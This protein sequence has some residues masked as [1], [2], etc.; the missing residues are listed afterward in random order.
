[1]AKQDDNS[2]S[3]P[4]PSLMPGLSTPHLEL[5]T[6]RPPSSSM[7]NL[8]ELTFHSNSTPTTPVT[9]NCEAQGGLIRR[10]SMPVK[11]LP[12]LDL[13]ALP[14]EIQ[15]QSDVRTARRRVETM[16]STLSKFRSGIY[17]GSEAAARDKNLLRRM[18]ITHIV[19]ANIGTPNYWEGEIEYL[20]VNVRDDRNERIDE[21]LEI[22]NGF[23]RDALRNGGKVAV[24]CR[25]GVSRSATI[26]IAYVMVSE[27][28]SLDE[29]MRRLRTVRPIVAPNSGFI[30]SLE[31][32]ERRLLRER[33]KSGQGSR[34]R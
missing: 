15:L 18:G 19:N 12:L 21:R 14:S 25:Q 28:W 26:A 24:L 9:D 32:L 8:D 33:S 4:S 5:P 1:M 34:T 17:V 23:I 2:V 16:V 6:G 10:A 13:N 3:L 7:P 27:G 29:A 22:T 30:E 11:R 20:K 31:R